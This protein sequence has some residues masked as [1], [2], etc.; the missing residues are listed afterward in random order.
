MFC[1]HLGRLEW[2]RLYNAGILAA[3]TSTRSVELKHVRR[4]DFDAEKRVVHIH[5]S[6][7]ETS[8]RVILLNDSAFGAV[9]RPGCAKH[10]LLVSD[11]QLLRCRYQRRIRR[12][13][14][15]TAHERRR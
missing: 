15:Q 10:H 7:N 14:S 12:P 2:E 11:P 9:P 8:K 3:T 5:A 4:K 13:H 1:D 6:K